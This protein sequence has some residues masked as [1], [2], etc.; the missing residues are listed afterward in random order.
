MKKIC[1]E[2]GVEKEL[3]EFYKHPQWV[4]WTLP[5]CKEC[6]KKWRRS[7]REREMSRII[8]NKRSKTEKR[9]KYQK[10]RDI[11]RNKTNQIKKNAHIKVWNFIRN[12]KGK[13]NFKCVICWKQD[14]I[15]KHHED[16]NKPNEI[17]PFC[18]LHHK[19]RHCWDFEVKKERIIILPF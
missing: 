7:E 10:K 8:D 13:Y 17:I 19:R 11:K 15:E 9:K 1:K 4:L 6:I 14:R 5:R 2:C 12:N 18:S 16:Y 3:T